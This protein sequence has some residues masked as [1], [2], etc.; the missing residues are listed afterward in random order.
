MFTCP[1]CGLTKHKL[2]VPA[3]PTSDKASL[4]AWM[5]ALGHWIKDEHHRVSPNCHHDKCDLYIPAPD[6]AE[7]LGQQTE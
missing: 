4:R 1:A 2:E 3:R 7:F 5:D 6:G